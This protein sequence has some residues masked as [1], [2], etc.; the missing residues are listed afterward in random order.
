MQP[1]NIV[2]TSSPCL[3]K[4]KLL[5]KQRRQTPGT[6]GLSAPFLGHEFHGYSWVPPGTTGGTS[7]SQ[8]MVPQIRLRGL[9]APHGTS[10]SCGDPKCPTSRKLRSTAHSVAGQEL[11]MKLDQTFFLDWHDSI[12]NQIWYDDSGNHHEHK[13]PRGCS[14]P[15]HYTLSGTQQVGCFRSGSCFRAVSD[16]NVFEIQLNL[17]CTGEFAG[18]P[19]DE[20]DWNRTLLIGLSWPDAPFEEQV[21]GKWATQKSTQSRKQ[22][23]VSE[24]VF[25]NHCRFL[26]SSWVLGHFSE[27]FETCTLMPGLRMREVCH[28]IF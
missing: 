3:A 15:N 6:P 14:L 16:L 2:H 22:I 24:I 7:W 11:K 13:H 9:R 4:V 18:H 8:K 10:I 27:T 25:P 21:M 12:D 20:N 28:T 19:W 5:P 23:A 1:K 17:H 26:G